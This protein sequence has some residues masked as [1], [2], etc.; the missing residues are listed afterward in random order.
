MMDFLSEWAVWHSHVADNCHQV[1]GLLV[2]ALM[3]EYFCSYKVS[4]HSREDSLFRSRPVWWESFKTLRQQ[5][6]KEELELDNVL[7]KPEKWYVD[8]NPSATPKRST[9]CIRSVGHVPWSMLSLFDHFQC[10]SYR[11]F[12]FP[13]GLLSLEGSGAKWLCTLNPAILY[14]LVVHSMICSHR[15]SS[16]DS[17]NTRNCVLDKA[18]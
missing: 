10:N 4:K 3:N 8:F 1:V 5:W 16:V 2:K 13:V 18:G 17:R 15:E 14:F 6:W 7:I 9:L 11:Y 12:F